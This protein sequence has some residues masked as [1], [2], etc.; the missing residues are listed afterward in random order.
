M[1]QSVSHLPSVSW[2]LVHAD[3]RWN[4]RKE[5]LLLLQYR[6][7]SE[8]LHSYQWCQ[9]SWYVDWALS[10]LLRAGGEDPRKVSC[11]GRPGDWKTAGFTAISK[12]LIIF[13]VVLILVR[14]ICLSWT[15]DRSFTWWGHWCVYAYHEHQDNKWEYDRGTQ[16]HFVFFDRINLGAGVLL[17]SRIRST[18]EVFLKRDRNRP[19]FRRC[20]D[21][22]SCPNRSSL[23]V[24]WPMTSRVRSHISITEPRCWFSLCWSVRSPRSRTA[25]F[26]VIWDS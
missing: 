20:L 16:R 14:I 22:K 10:P 6:L 25:F 3:G 15:R 11:V 24:R 23:K 1:W 18:Y 2:K 12:R 26:K 13:V 17:I 5:R 7:I 4:S 21:K 9:I 19:H 8:L